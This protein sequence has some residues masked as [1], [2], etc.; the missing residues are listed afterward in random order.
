MGFLAGKKILITGLLSDRSIAYGV[1]RACKREGAELAFTYQMERFKDRVAKLASH[2][3]SELLFPC[4][5][6]N[7]QEIEALFASLGHKWGGL[8]GLLHSIAFAEKEGLSG[9]FVNN[10]TRDVFAKANDVSAYSFVALARAA[11]S[12]MQGRE[13]AL[14]TLSYLGAERVIPNYNMMGVAK[15]ALEAT[16]RYMA[17]SLGSE[18]IRVNAVSAGPIKTLAASG[19]EGFSKILS[20]V[21]KQSL[22]KRNVTTD[23]VGNVAAFL[24]SELS[25]GMTGETLYV[26]SGY[27]HTAGMAEE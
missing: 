15:A 11:R 5:V 4:D 19:I 25:R 10:V 2:F 17:A 24:F 18:G 21:E 16:T 22:L 7:D 12:L 26:D 9:D 14:V 13:A 27:H 20:H 23:E 3:D 8:D 1:A 6:G